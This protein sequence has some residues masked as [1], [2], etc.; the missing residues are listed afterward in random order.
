MADY[1]TM[2]SDPATST[3]P[4]WAKALELMDEGVKLVHEGDVAAALGR[5]KE[6]IGI[7]ETSG[8]WFNVGVSGTPYSIV[9][10]HL[11]S[12]HSDDNNEGVMHKG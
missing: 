2:S 4:S 1:A 3:D 8:G 7:R 11:F 10:F 12:S 6:S 9:F 5:L